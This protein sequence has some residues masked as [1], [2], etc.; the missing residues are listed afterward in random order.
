G[1][2]GAVQ[3]RHR[4]G[5]SLELYGLAQLTLDD[6]DGGYADNDMFAFGGQ[7]LFGDRSSVGGEVS[8][9]DRGDA[10]TLTAEYRLQPDHSLYGSY[11]WSTDTTRYDSLFNPNR[12]NGWTLG[13]RWRLSQQVNL[14]NESQFLK[15]PDGS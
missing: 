1:L 3:Y 2:L 10:A 13:Q 6:D 12:Q 8:T 14:F 4:F 11:S 9:G 5:T 7:Y 15:D